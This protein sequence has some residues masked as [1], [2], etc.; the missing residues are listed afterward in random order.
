[1]LQALLLTFALATVPAD[2]IRTGEDVI[3]A[4]HGRYA[5]K[6]YENLALIQAVTYFDLESG[7][8][9]SAR[10]WYESIQLPG[11]VRSDIAPLEQGDYQL[12]RD[13]TWHIFEADTLT[14]SNPGAHPVLLLGFDVYTQPVEQTLASLERFDLSKL[15][16]ATW[17]GREV[18][19]VGSESEGDAANQFWVDRDDLLLR[20][21]IIVS[22]ASG[23]TIEIRFNAYE[24]LGGGWI[25]AELSFLRDGRLWLHERYAYWAI[26]VEFEPGI[27][28]VTD[29]TRPA[30]VGR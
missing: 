10:M 22:R 16:Q 23:A 9:D 2:S 21:L 6:W 7:A 14:G 1:M 3:R 4:M 25:A 12:Y 27:F 28:A 11:T 20:R 5:G 18:Y 29:G 24:E 26:D 15:R 19:V 13:G 17:Q 30:W 8:L